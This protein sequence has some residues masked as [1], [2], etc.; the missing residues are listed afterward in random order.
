M[1]KTEEQKRKVRITAILLGL[2]ALGFYI[3]FFFLIKN[4]N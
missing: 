4:S 3:G 2:L 1:S